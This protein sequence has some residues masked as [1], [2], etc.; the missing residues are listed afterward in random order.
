MRA[1][2]LTQDFQL[3]TQNA[4]GP[5]TESANARFQ[6]R[7]LVSFSSRNARLRSA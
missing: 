1:A 2:C 7:A 5:L 3:K 4:K 6:G